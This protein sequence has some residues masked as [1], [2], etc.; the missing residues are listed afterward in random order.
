MSFLDFNLRQEYIPLLL[1]ILGLGYRV[2]NVYPNY[3]NPK[4]SLLWSQPPSASGLLYV[5]SPLDT[6]H[7]ECMSLLILD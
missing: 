4:Y 7:R 1:F 2:L 5:S 6:E 3:Y